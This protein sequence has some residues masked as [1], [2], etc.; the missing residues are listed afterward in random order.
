MQAPQD[1][2][3]FGDG[4]LTLAGLEC[5]VLPPCHVAARK[6]SATDMYIQPLSPAPEKEGDWLLGYQTAA[7]MKNW[8][9]ERF[10]GPSV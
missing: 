8:A 7:A 4:R 6:A 10:E 2:S 3:V 9:K 5:C 1:L